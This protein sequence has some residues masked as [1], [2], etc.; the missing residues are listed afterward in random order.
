MMEFVSWDDDIPN[1]ME[2]HSCFEAPTRL[3]HHLGYLNLIKYLLFPI[4]I[5][6]FTIAKYSIITTHPIQTLFFS[7]SDF[8][9]KHNQQK[10]MTLVDDPFRH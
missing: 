7:L 3:K 4:S 6:N 10:N 8:L 5:V 2:K 9:L 1:M